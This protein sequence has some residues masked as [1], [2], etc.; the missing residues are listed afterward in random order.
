MLI[1]LNFRN[2]SLVENGNDKR[3]KGKETE[4]VNFYHLLYRRKNMKFRLII[5]I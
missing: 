2:V 1:R 3:V 5:K 4:R